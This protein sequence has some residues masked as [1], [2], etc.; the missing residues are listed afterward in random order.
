MGFQPQQYREEVRVSGTTVDPPHFSEETV[1][2]PRFQAQRSHV[3]V[4]EETVDPPRFSRKSNKM[5]YYDEDGHYHSIRHGLHKAADRVLG[6]HHHH[7]HHNH[8]DRE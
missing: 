1:D 6:R 8:V 7:H 5:G 4:S 2:P 3:H